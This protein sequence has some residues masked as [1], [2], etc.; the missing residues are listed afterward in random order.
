[1][2]CQLAS[3]VI[4]KLCEYHICPYTVVFKDISQPYSKEIHDIV[5][6]FVI[7]ILGF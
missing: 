1:M 3:I 7:E 4:S 5:Y 6:I 2:Q